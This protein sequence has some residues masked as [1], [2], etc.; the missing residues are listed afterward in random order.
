M[1]A[2]IL[3]GG[4]GAR[5]NP[6]TI[7]FPKPLMP[8]SGLPILQIVISQ[9]KNNG[10]D[11]ITLA[12]GYMADMIKAY[13]NG[14]TKFDV[15][16]DYSQEDHPL[17][18]IGALSLIKDLPDNFL[19]MNGDILTDLDFSR[20]FNF[21]LEEGA[22]ATIATYSKEVNIEYGIIE[23]G[24]WDEIIGYR[25]KPIMNYQVSMGIYA[26]NSK[27][28]QH[29]EP[30]SYLDFPKLVNFL[31][32]KGERVVSFPVSGYWRDIGCYSDY[33]KAV[34]DFDKMRDTFLCKR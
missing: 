17:G 12:V 27:I 20:F 8:I 34:E 10:F 28:I 15:R 21:H 3:A 29:I 11:H 6:Y 9:L 5:L 16:I 18:T 22:I 32:D 30:G 2:V 23:C 25:E 1:R 26:F 19:V 31:I 4:K 14:K 24:D 33:E 13:F 7:V